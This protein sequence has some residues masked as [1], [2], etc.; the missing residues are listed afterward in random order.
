MTER[1]VKN[2]LKRITRF[3]MARIKKRNRRKT[4]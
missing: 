1:T 4:T 2:G 3:L